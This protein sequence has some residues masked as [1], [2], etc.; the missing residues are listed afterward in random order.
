VRTKGK[1]VRRRYLAGVGVLLLI[2]SACRSAPRGYQLAPGE[3]FTPADAAASDGADA[4]ETGG[5]E[6][7]WSADWPMYL[8]SLG[9]TSRNDAATAITPQTA[10][11]LSLAW[12]WRPDPPTQEGQPP[13]QM[14]AAPTVVAGRLYVGANTGVFYALDAATGSVLWQR[15]LGY[16]TGETC[17]QRG[18]TST[19]TVVNDANGTPTV[20]VGG[21]DG[22][23]YAL[24]AEDGAI[25]WKATVVDPGEGRNEGY[26]WSS[27]AVVDGRVYTGVAS[28]CGNPQIRGGEKVF[29]QQ[30]GKLEGAYWVVPKGAV[31]GSVWSSPAAAPQGDIFISTGNAD[32]TEKDP[33]GDSYSIVRL[34]GA[35]LSRQDVWTAKQLFGTDLDFGGSPTLFGGAGARAMVGACNKDGVYYALH[36]QQLSA[37]P[38]WQARISIDWSDGGNCLGGAVW[39][40]ARSRVYLAGGLTT[41]AGKRVPGSVRALNAQT[42]K[43]VWQRALDAP[44]W[45][46]TSLNGAGVLAVPTFGGEGAAVNGVYLVEARSGRLLAHVET[47]GSP[48]F[49][50]PVFSD[51]YLFLSTQ[52]QGLL[53]LTPGSAPA[54]P[55]AASSSPAAE[56]SPAANATAAEPSAAESSPKG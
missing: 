22:N 10:A 48:V 51:R 31:G 55:T 14:L 34:N 19:A 36:P 2:V 13:A 25:V 45:G 35:D 12:Q 17:G 27:P 4:A 47:N 39:D 50:Q 11:S 16:A 40:P 44:V 46:S 43:P 56:S 28:Q 18:I 5:T 37:G 24:R 15:S 26:V 21:G 30:T 6:S 7:A 54:N 52:S 9:H 42:G 20:Y 1:N 29:D 53:A 49:A 23:L 33:P 8:Y 38:V 32:P 3:T 41:L